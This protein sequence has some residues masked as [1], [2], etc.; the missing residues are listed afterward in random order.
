MPDAEKMDLTI[1]SK[2]VSSGKSEGVCNED[3]SDKVVFGYISSKNAD[4]K[5]EERF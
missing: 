1:R 2:A 3:G 4:R 5:T